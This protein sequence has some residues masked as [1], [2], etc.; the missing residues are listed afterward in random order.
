MI[1]TVSGNKGVRC[2]VSDSVLAVD[3]EK[4]A[5]AGSDI[6]VLRTSKETP[7]EAMDTAEIIG[8]GEYE[9]SGI[10][11][12]GVQLDKESNAKKIRTAY[13]VVMDEIKLAFLGDS[14][15]ADFSEE[16]LDALGDADILFVPEANKDFDVKKI[17]HMIKQI[18]PHV[19]IPLND[20]AAL[21]LAKEIGQKPEK[22]EKLVIKKKELLEMNSKLIVINS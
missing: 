18:E 20:K 21:E 4:G 9:I 12:N 16:V 14:L 15:N 3:P 10:K 22:M 19:I 8:A 13:L 5:R 2:Q 6:L 11:V 1:I 7:I 17:A